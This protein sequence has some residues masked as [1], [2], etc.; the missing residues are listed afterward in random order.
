MSGIWKDVKGYEGIYQV[1]EC[2]T[3]KSLDRRVNT[4]HGDRLSK[5][6]LLKI[7]QDR[8]GYHYV[9]LSKNGKGHNCKIHRL[10]CD[11]FH[12][13]KTGQNAV[14]H[15]DGNKMNNCAANLEWCTNKQNTNHAIET[16]LWKNIGEMAKDN[17]LSE[18]EVLEIRRNHTDSYDKLADKYNVSKSTVADIKK[19]RSWKWLGGEM[20]L[21]TKNMNREKLPEELLRIR[22]ERHLTKIAFAKEIRVAVSTLIRWENGEIFPKDGTLRVLIEEYGVNLSD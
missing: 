6:K 17:I 5:G 3:V 13:R 11:A 2:G 12:E 19:F 14:N 15:I 18:Q 10:V 16:G 7:Q 4:K 1:S 21:N 8:T 20:L 22:S 9:H